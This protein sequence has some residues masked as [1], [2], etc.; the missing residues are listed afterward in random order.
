MASI[1][2]KLNN[3]IK[4]KVPDKIS[5]ESKLSSSMIV[6]CIVSIIIVF[7]I[8]NLLNTYLFKIRQCFISTKLKVISRFYKYKSFK[9]DIDMRKKQEVPGGILENLIT[10]FCFKSH[11]ISTRKIMKMVYLADVY[12]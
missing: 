2:N 11:P 9:E 3:F 8:F 10:Y 7:V 5:E 4:N 1:Y 6:V 12:H